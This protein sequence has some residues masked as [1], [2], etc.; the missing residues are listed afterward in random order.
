MMEDTDKAMNVCTK[1]AV[2]VDVDKQHE[3]ETL[4]EKNKYNLATNAYLK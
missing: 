2:Q 1:G 4:K 3:K